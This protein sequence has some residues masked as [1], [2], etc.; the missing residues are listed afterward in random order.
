M[1]KKL[2][3][4]LLGLFMG[5]AGIGFG[6]AIGK[7]LKGNSL[8]IKVRLA[9]VP[10]MILAAWLVLAAHEFGHVVGGW[11]AGFRFHF[12]AVGP[13]RIDRLGSRFTVKF[14][15]T[16]SLW[17]GMAACGPDPA[18]IPTGDALRRRML[19]LV[20]G[21]PA[22]S[23]LGGLMA[24]PA[25]VFWQSN[26]DMAL[27][28]MVFAV[29]SLSIALVTMLPIGNHGYVNDGGRILSLVRDNADARRWM[30]TATLGTIGSEARP[31]DWPA[32][33][34]HEITRDPQPTYDGIMAMWLRYSWHL[35]R[36]EFA[37][38]KH[39]LDL[40]LSHV[41]QWPPAA[42]PILHSSAAHFYSQLETDLPRARQHLAEARKPG[43]L[44]LEAVALSE[45]SVLL[46]EG[47]RAAARERIGEGRRL[48][49]DTSGTAR[50]SLRELI[51]ELAAKT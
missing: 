27:G 36:K 18:K 51:E 17:G 47:D 26:P 50:D 32:A 21:G 1:S 38:A 12:F 33:L 39:W 16:L 48:L 20:A 46:A 35:D 31:R 19:L 7:L 5:V 43:F 4:V 44:Q 14:N 45:A 15:R 22:T 11:L 23:L 29:A 8:E 28:F 6:Y 41:E 37:E 25:Q 24:L 10:V 9:S 42:R 40:A 3:Q 13:L 34:V 49:A 2:K 30:A